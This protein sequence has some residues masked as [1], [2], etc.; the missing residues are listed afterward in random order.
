MPTK[1]DFNR[2][3]DEVRESRVVQVPAG[4]DL[5]GG[6]GGTSILGDV[7]AAWYQITAAAAIVGAVGSWTYTVNQV[8]WSGSDWTA[9]VTGLTAYNTIEHQLTPIHGS[10]VDVTN[11]PKN[12]SGTALFAVM[13]AA[14]GAVVLGSYSGGVLWFQYENAVDGT[15][16]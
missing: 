2:L 16:A 7:R 15:C 13:P 10:G 14:V 8:T 4:L 6:P 9:V 12:F 1:E 11:L 3:V 5:R